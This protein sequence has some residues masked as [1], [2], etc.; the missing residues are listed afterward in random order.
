MWDS[1]F[2]VGGASGTDLQLADCPAGATSVNTD[3]KAA[4]LLLHVTSQA[5]GYFE[6]IWAWV[7]DHDL[8]NALNAAASESDVSTYLPT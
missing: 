2:R 5:S 7:A 1:H 4:S 6:N 8:D 3:C